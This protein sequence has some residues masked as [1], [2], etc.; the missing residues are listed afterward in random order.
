MADIL[1][2]EPD[3]VL[4]KT[5]G[6]YLES[7]GHKIQWRSS[8]Q[9]AINSADESPPDVVILE[10]QLPSNSG[11][12][13]LYEFRSYPEWQAV[14]V[15]VLSTFDQSEIAS[16]SIMLGSLEVVAYHHKH[17]TSLQQIADTIDQALSLAQK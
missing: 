17:H 2:I 5:I 6:E 11:V 7:K 9:Y 15:I 14:P 3:M 10:L 13:F 12:E 8:A 4:A 16:S 1:L